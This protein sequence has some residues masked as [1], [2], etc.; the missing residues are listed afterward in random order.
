MGNPP[1]RQQTTSNQHP[2]LD[3]FYYV[4]VLER[5][6]VCLGLLLALLSR[7][8]HLHL[9]VL[10]RILPNAPCVNEPAPHPSIHAIWEN[11]ALQLIDL[12]E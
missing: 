10:C 12:T 11:G 3:E 4:Q 1:C 8:P 6:L 5:G 9:H 2:F 7:R